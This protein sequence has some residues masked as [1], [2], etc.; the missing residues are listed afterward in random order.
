[1]TAQARYLYSPLESP[2]RLEGHRDLG[3]APRRGLSMAS[4]YLVGG[5]REAVG[6]LPQHKL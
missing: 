3:F 4:K 5:G 2:P 6:A 1:M